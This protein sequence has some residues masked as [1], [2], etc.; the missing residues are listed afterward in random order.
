LKIEK[1]NS[2]AIFKDSIMYCTVLESGGKNLSYDLKDNRVI[3]SYF[4]GHGVSIAP[5]F[6][7][8]KIIANAESD[9]L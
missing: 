8:D 9:N 2:Q 5:N 7:K 6:F 4:I 3:W 1:I